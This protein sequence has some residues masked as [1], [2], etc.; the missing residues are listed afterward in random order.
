MLLTFIGLLI[1]R[2]R[3]R[4]LVY[5]TVYIICSVVTYEVVEFEENNLLKFNT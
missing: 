4:I 5:Q 1:F 2:V 3:V